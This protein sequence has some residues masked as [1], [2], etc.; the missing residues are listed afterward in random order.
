MELEFSM[1]LATKTR[2]AHL[3]KVI[4]FPVVPRVGEYVKFRNTVVGD[5]FAFRVSEIT[6]REAGLIEVWTERL[7]NVED[8]MYSFE[9]EA[10]F[11][12]YYTSYLNEAGSVGEGWGLI[13]IVS[14]SRSNLSSDQHSR[15]DH[16]SKQL[17]GT[18]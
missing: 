7:D 16:V 12:E 14:D 5:Y 1:W 11:D 8:R 2:W 18:C 10:E 9:T 17:H 6:Y 15:M 13:D 4:P 3:S